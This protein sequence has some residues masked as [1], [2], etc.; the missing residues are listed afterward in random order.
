[1][2]DKLSYVTRSQDPNMVLL[3]DQDNGQDNSATFYFPMICV[4]FLTWPPLNKHMLESKSF[5]LV[6]L[7]QVVQ[8]EDNQIQFLGSIDKK[9]LWWILAAKGVEGF[10]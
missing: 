8:S 7:Y 6:R 2:G 9:I 4:N 1:M 10:E 3:E 5:R